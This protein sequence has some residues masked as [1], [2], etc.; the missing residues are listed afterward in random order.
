MI[1]IDF[2][3]LL[4]DDIFQHDTSA[5]NLNPKAYIK[6]GTEELKTATFHCIP[7]NR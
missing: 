4:S 6:P 1:S 3:E 5:D 2:P 7:T